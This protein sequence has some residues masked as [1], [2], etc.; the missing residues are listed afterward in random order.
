MTQAGVRSVILVSRPGPIFGL[1]GC[2]C[3]GGPCEAAKTG[4]S[5]SFRNQ[6]GS[7]NG[8]AT[9]TNLTVRSL[10]DGSPDALNSWEAWVREALAA[11]LGLLSVHSPNSLDFDLDEQAS[12]GYG[13]LIE[14][15]MRYIIDHQK[16]ME[17]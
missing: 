13:P 3:R 4:R 11:G 10:L 7:G 15:K 16:K 2:D 12:M 14:S 1:S 9:K 5:T 6:R 17:G 8:R